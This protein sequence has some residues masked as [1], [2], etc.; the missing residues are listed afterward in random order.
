MAVPLAGSDAIRGGDLPQVAGH[1]VLARLWESAAVVAYVARDREGATVTLCAVQPRLA[2][3]GTVRRRL[4]AEAGLGARASGPWMVPVWPLTDDCFVTAYRPALPL[5]VA[6]T[7]H[8]PLPEHALRVLGAALAETLTR[9]HT[10]V[11]AHQGLAPHTVQLASDG[12]LLTGFGPLGAATAVGLDG[13]EPRL[14]LGY[15]TPEQ[16]ARHAPGPAS[17]VFV[18]GLLLVYAATGGGPFPAATPDAL[19]SAD[20]E[21]SG[22]PQALRPL[23]A[24]CLAKA[25]RDRP[26]PRDI[27]AE[28]A[29]HGVPELLAE[30]WLPGPLMAELSEQAAAVMALD[31]PGTEPPPAEPDTG[32]LV[33]TRAEDVP[34][35]RRPGRRT[36]LV[37][38]AGLVAGAAGGFGLARAL[39]PDRRAPAAQAA[40]RRVE[41]TAPAA[42]WHYKARDQGKPA[43]VWR[44]EIVVLPVGGQIVGLDL[45][46]GKERWSKPMYS[47]S[48]VPVR[49][50]LLLTVASGKLTTFSARTGVVRS[51]DGRY[52]GYVTADG[53]FLA[54]DGGQVWFTIRTTGASFLVCYDLAHGDE[55]W[56]AG[57]P[58]DLPYVRDF[59]V[60]EDAVHARV[61]DVDALPPSMPDENDKHPAVFTSYDRATGRQLRRRSYGGVRSKGFA[62]LSP[63]GVLYASDR[64]LK[65]YDLAGGKLL[66]TNS[67]GDARP[68]MSPRA[69][70]EVGDALYVVDSI[71]HTYK[72]DARDGTT[73]WEA[74]PADQVILFDDSVTVAL[75]TGPR[76]T[77][78]LRLDGLNVTAYDPRDGTAQWVFEGVGDPYPADDA[79]VWQLARG[80]RIGVFSRRM[81]PHYFALPIG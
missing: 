45:S 43:T 61:V 53:G 64:G 76:N 5:D 54:H 38:G 35:P 42:L 31:P 8:G 26:A 18:L 68:V 72:V 66:W 46:T 48:P 3:S 59:T 39:T 69:V 55:V 23:L 37:A 9:L 25:P 50:D 56:R 29:P 33:A 41:R 40:P 10:L 28:L 62:W 24:R 52:D 14:T 27:A 67:A 65:A 60:G 49:D 70:R 75:D 71:R 1:R 22:V 74:K 36:L 2:A 44:D 78:L 57:L 32:T 20:A 15:L 47:E 7:R 19:A 17:D 16:V 80:S 6:V 13:A 58:K 21:L 79:G 12:P 63:K 34:A 4:R 77:P 30:G 11:P 81:S 73:R 51:A